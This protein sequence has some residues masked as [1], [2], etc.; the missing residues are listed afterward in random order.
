M[1]AACQTLT[2][3]AEPHIP[4]TVNDNGSDVI[5]AQPFCIG[6]YR[7]LFTGY[8]DPYSAAAGRQPDQ[9]LIK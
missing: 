5:A 6:K 2:E 4:I 7:E 8:L 1:A 9:V 3:G